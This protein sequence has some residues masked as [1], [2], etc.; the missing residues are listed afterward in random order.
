MIP[1]LI[2]AGVIIGRWWA[3]PIAAIVWPAVL[4]G[5]HVGGGLP[6]ILSAAALGAANTAVG[7]AAH[8]IGIK[9]LRKARRALHEI[10]RA[11]V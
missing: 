5:R 1:V 10:G 3:L 2:V 6:F 9:L 7:V 8:K 4:I 11:H